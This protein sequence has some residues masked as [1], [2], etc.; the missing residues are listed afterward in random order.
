MAAPQSTM[1]FRWPE[2]N[3]CRHLRG[4]WGFC[5][6]GWAVARSEFDDATRRCVARLSSVKRGSFSL[7]SC[8][9]VV[10]ESV[11]L[12]CVRLWGVWHAKCKA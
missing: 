6:V 1:D 4:L 2:T 9:R 7:H 5:D 10:D 8:A 11:V 12:A 3:M